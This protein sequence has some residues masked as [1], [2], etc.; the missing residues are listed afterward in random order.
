MKNKTSENKYLSTNPV[1]YYNSEDEIAETAD[2][3]AKIASG[4]V[5]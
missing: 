5:G 2:L 1:H 4:K 3:V